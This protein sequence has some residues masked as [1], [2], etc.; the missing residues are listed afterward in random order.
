MWSRRE[1][2][3]VARQRCKE[4]IN[5]LPSTSS[6]PG[7]K[8]EQVDL[9]DQV[10]APKNTRKMA[11]ERPENEGVENVTDYGVNGLKMSMDSISLCT[12]EKKSD[13]I[14]SNPEGTVQSRITCCSKTAK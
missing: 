9:T 10:H 1:R 2:K 3:E 7:E 5:N 14:H 8:I 6:P 13:G 11:M 12:R 4:W